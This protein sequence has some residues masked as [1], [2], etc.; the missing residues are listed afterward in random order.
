MVVAIYI[1]TNN[2]RMFPILHILC[3]IIVYRCFDHGHS[4]GY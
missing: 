4:D 2:A 3:S 1:A